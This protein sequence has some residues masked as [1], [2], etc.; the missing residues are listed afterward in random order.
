[1]IER[2]EPDPANRPMVAGILWKRI[3]NAWNLGVDATSRYTIQDWNDRDAFMKQLRDPKD[4]YNTR[5][6]PGLPATAIGNPGKTALEAAADPTASDYW[7][8]L[9]DSTHT[10]HPSRTVAEH[11][12]ARKKYDVY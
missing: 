7:Y 1:M 12:A 5:L 9:H 6:R 2:E 3:D 8:Y 10:L 4:P 11:E